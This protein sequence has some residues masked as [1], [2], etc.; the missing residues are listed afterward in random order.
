MAREFPL[1]TVRTVAHQR[2]E[3]AARALNGHSARLRAAEE[4]LSQ[5]EGYRDEYRAQLANAM[6]QGVQAG[7]LRD[8]NAFLA[9]LDEAITQQGVDVARARAVW[10]QALQHWQELDQR[11]QAMDTLLQQHEAAERA[12]ESKQEQKGQDEAAAR[13]GRLVAPR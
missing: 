7:R 2:A 4:K 13:V 12:L 1:E 11:G 10:E 8:Y 5:L 9:R 6:A 3:D